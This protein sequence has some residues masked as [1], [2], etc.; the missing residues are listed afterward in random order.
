VIDTSVDVD[1]RV[2][3]NARDACGNTALHYAASREDVELAEILLKHPNI[4]TDI[5]NSSGL[6]PG[7]YCRG[8]WYYEL[9]LRLSRDEK[10]SRKIKGYL[11]RLIQPL[12]TRPL[13]LLPLPPTNDTTGR[14]VSS[15]ESTQASRTRTRLPP[16]PPPRAT[17]NVGLSVDTAEPRRPGRTTLPTCR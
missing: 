2:D 13:P 8:R 14:P 15:T 17:R 6:T 12:R 16:A 11:G 9:A 5:E 7:E 1:A 10:A 3:V 4:K